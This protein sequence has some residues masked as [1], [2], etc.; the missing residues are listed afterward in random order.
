MRPTAAPAGASPHRR[1]EAL[2]SRRGGGVELLRIPAAIYGALVGLR[3]ALYDHGWLQPARLDVPVVSVGNLTAGGTGKTP[4]THWLAG[5][6]LRRG[7]RPG[8]LSRGYRAR[9]AGPPPDGVSDGRP[10]GAPSDVPG[11]VS[12]DEARLGAELLPDVPH[13]Q[14]AD[15]IAGAV[16]LLEHG[17]DVVLLDDGFQ[18]RRL[19]RDLDLVL[20]DATRPWGLP[21]PQRGGRQVR[22]LLPR[23]LLREPPLA[24]G[25]ADALVLTRVDQVDP[26]RLEELEAELLELAP[27]RPLVHATHRPWRLRDAGGAE[28]AP[29]ELAGREV[30]LVSGIGNPD[31]FEATVR[32]LGA[33]VREHRRLADHHAYRGGELDGLGGEGR[34]IVTT[35]KDAVKRRGP[36]AGPHPLVLDVRL[37]LVRGAGVLAALLDALPRSDRGRQRASLHEGLHG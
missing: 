34:W 21:A 35:A 17:V 26:A 18:H 2:L 23:G 16:E 30:D 10:H 12:S 4:M 24:L 27:G 32:G 3:G 33:R 25:R 14:R 19:A 15:R 22:A 31:A 37:E 29:E 5:E 36:G 1:P 20:V 11:D 9:A 8:L 13:V 6:L 28:R 7:R